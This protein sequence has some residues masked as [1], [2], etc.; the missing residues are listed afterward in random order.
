MTNKRYFLSFMGMEKEVTRKEWIDA[1][2]SAGFRSKFGNDHEA[3]GGFSS[4]S[5]ICGRIEY[6]KEV[7]NE[8]SDN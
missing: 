7:P 1:E 4:G 2:Q 8:N 5:G 6:V 3:T